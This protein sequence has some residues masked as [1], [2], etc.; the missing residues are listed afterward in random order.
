M[1]IV[2]KKKTLNDDL[3]AIKNYY[4]NIED[5]LFMQLIALDPTYKENSNSAGTYGKWILNIYNQGRLKEE[6]FYKVTDELKEFEKKKKYFTNKDIG[7]FKDL[8]DLAN[9]LDNVEVPDETQ[10]TQRQLEKQASKI[11]KAADLNAD[12]VY[13]DSDWIIYTPKDYLSSCKL[14]H[15]TRWCT[16][17]SSHG[18]AGYYNRYTSQ[19]PLY[20]VHNKHNPSEKYQFHDYTRQFMDKNDSSVYSIFKIFLGNNQII[21]WCKTHLP[22]IYKR[23]LETKDYYENDS[24]YV[25]SIR[26]FLDEIYPAGYIPSYKIIEE[27]EDYK[28]IKPDDTFSEIYLQTNGDKNEIIDSKLFSKN[29][30]IGYNNFR[31][32]KDFLKNINNFKKL[33]QEGYYLIS[34][35]GEVKN[36]FDQSEYLE[37]KKNKQ[38]IENYIRTIYPEGYEA[39]K[40]DIFNNSIIEISRPK[41]FISEYYLTNNGNLNNI[42]H[43][44]EG[45]FI[46]SKLKI[47][48]SNLY[49]LKFKD[50]ETVKEF[51]ENSSVSNGYT[52][53]DKN[54]EQGSVPMD[55]LY[56]GDIG[57]G[58]A[59]GSELA[60]F[61]K[62]HPDIYK[63]FYG[64]KNSPIYE[65]KGETAEVKE[66]VTSLPAWFF[67]SNKNNIKEIHIPS[68]VRYVDL[69]AFT[70]I[71]NLRKIIVD[72]N[73]PYLYSNNGVLYRKKDDKVY[74]MPPEQIEDVIPERMAKGKTSLKNFIIPKT[75]V[76]IKNEAFEGSGLTEIIIPGNVKII[77]DRAFNKCKNLKNI[78]IENGVQ[79]IGREAFSETAIEK[80]YIPS[81]VSVLGDDFI[82]HCDNLKEVSGLEGV[83]E[84]GYHSYWLREN[85]DWGNY[86]TLERRLGE[87]EIFGDQNNK[88][89]KIKI[90]TNNQTLIN[91]FNKYTNRRSNNYYQIETNDSSINDAIKKNSMKKLKFNEWL[92]KYYNKK[93]YDLNEKLLKYYHKLYLDYC[94]HID[95]SNT[96]FDKCDIYLD[97]SQLNDVIK[98]EA[99]GYVI[100]SEKGKKL[101]KA[102]KTKEEAEKRL[103]QIEYF[104]HKG[105]DSM[106][107]EETK[108]YIYQFP[109]DLT[110]ADMRYLDK[111]N[112]EYIGH[113]SKEGDQPEDVLVKGTLKDL[114]D[115][116]EECLAYDLNDNYLYEVDEF[117]TELIDDTFVKDSSYLNYDIVKTDNG[118]YQV[119]LDGD[120]REYPTIKEARYAIDEYVYPDI[121]KEPFKEEEKAEY[122]VYAEDIYK[123]VDAMNLY[124]KHRGRAMYSKEQDADLFTKSQAEKIENF[125]AGAHTWKKKKIGDSK[126]KDSGKFYEGTDVYDTLN[127]YLNWEGIQG[128]TQEIIDVWNDKEAVIDGEL[129]QFDTSEDALHAYLEWEGIIGY[130]WDIMDILEGGVAYLEGY[131]ENEDIGLEDSS[132]VKDSNKAKDRLKVGQIVHLDPNYNDILN[133][134]LYEDDYEVV[135]FQNNNKEIKIDNVPEDL[136]DFSGI[137]IKNKRLGV[138][139]CVC[140]FQL[141]DSNTVKTIDELIADEEETIKKYEEAMKTADEKH[142]ALYSHII[143]EELEHIEELKNIKEMK[144]SKAVKENMVKGKSYDSS[145]VMDVLKKCKETLAKSSAKDYFN[146]YHKKDGQQ[147]KIILKGSLDYED[148]DTEDRLI[149]KI[150]K[151]IKEFY[152][153]SEFEYSEKFAGGTWILKE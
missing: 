30:E 22:N 128:Y 28:I 45:K 54:G 76:E 130:D 29:I 2:I 113:V 105:K 86:W 32:H 115:Y 102:Y 100:Y 18:D 136:M 79:L 35:D 91:N 126:I 61:S 89:N 5:N 13:E 26:E 144:D 21:D 151:A 111:Y 8:A 56:H 73:N 67:T 66:G 140:R 63:Y 38:D 53:L 15:N 59:R 40:E 65:L 69:Y 58:S 112:L 87:I 74:F 85:E 108:L 146:I 51:F 50:L 48:L 34:K 124:Y 90:K 14:S 68:T 117:D 41:D 11:E 12:V 75:V 16:G 129:K 62:E 122:V 24:K 131:D 148:T 133:D 141:K 78:I 142:K 99:D 82:S 88:E 119:N 118:W 4:P 17:E 139:S 96:D 52:Y 98:K 37:W 47:N 10:L 147:D 150:T 80:L 81:S 110:K 77:G 72:P 106:M 7:Q 64:G 116:A 20:I 104:K 25:N 145:D 33:N 44:F 137:F 39:K 57:W 95:M 36:I 60:K 149:A 70:R 42:I 92:E 93:P 83:K 27:K 49:T 101:S 46:S 153:N 6:D 23:S 103:K 107:E 125:K 84:T 121:H 3:A 134:E 1:R 43:S 132:T 143:T 127:K 123:G 135:G 9:G 152:E 109:K 97:D 55:D 138:K 19:G 114:T 31:D 120:I 94:D 71:P